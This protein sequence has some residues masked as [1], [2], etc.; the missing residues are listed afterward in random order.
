MSCSSESKPRNVGFES[1]E[2]AGQKVRLRPTTAADA[3]AA[4]KLI[5]NNR[6]ILK[7]LC[8]GGPAD[9]AELTETYGNKWPLQ[10]RAGEKYSFAVEEIGNPGVFIGACDA[11]ILRYPQQFEVGYWMGKPYWGKG[12]ATEVLSLLSWLC[13]KRLGAEVVNSAAFVGNLASRR[14][15]EKNGF[16]FDGTLRRDVYK[17]GKWIDLWMLSLLPSEWKARDF[18][19]AAEKLKEAR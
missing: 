18:K 12:Y 4:W 16:H 8:W 5:H 17:D 2:L 3:P 11:R 6:D 13:F 15:M 14:V 1:V 19:P 7:W 9:L 10:L